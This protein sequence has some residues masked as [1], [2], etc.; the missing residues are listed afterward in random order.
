MRIVVAGAGQFGTNIAQLLAAENFDIVV[1]DCDKEDIREAQSV[2]DCLVVEGDACSTG[3]F[4]RPDVADADLFIACMGLDERNLVACMLAKHHGIKQTVACVRNADFMRYEQEFVTQ[5]MQIDLLLNT[6]YVMAKEIR[7]ILTAS[8]SLNVENFAGGKVKMFEGLISGDMPFANKTLK[9]LMLPKDILAA[10][11]LHNSKV[12]VPHG[13]TV[14]HEGD[15]VYFVGT[16]EAIQEFE[17][18]FSTVYEKPK[19]VLMIGAGRTGRFAAPMLEH[20]GLQVKAIEKDE[21]RCQ[22][23]AAELKSGMVLCGNG[24]NVEL[25]KEEGIQEADVVLAVTDDDQLNLT[26]AMLAKHLGAKRS[27]VRVANNDFLGMM[28]NLGVDVVLSTR[29]LMAEELLRFVHRGDVLNV[30]MLDD[31]QAEALE[32]VVS[33]GSEVAGKAVKDLQLTESA[34]LCA[35]VRD[36]DAYIPKGDTILNVGDRLVL[37]TKNEDAVAVTK[38]FEGREE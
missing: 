8:S 23:L 21:E 34:L 14:L 30:S 36:Q 27:V 10:L 28:E 32:I 7:R 16:A 35:V 2:V 33:E 20:K 18:N 1:V 19:K 22:Q 6:D 25:L 3:L 12:L 26:V 11:A 24:T 5:V 38:K 17:K 4:Q 13:D 15:Y 9:D 37:M 31:A 29:N